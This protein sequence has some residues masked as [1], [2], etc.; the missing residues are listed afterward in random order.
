MNKTAHQKKVEALQLAAE[1]LSD[2]GEE[3]LHERV[4]KRLDELNAQTANK[5]Q[6]M[7]QKEKGGDRT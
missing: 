1:I 7:I 4:V 3:K 2:A 5:I 6:E